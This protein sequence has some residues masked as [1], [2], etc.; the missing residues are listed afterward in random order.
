M[1]LQI[2][3]I[4]FSPKRF[5]KSHLISTSYNMNFSDTAMYLYDKKLGPETPG[6][7]PGQWG[8]QLV[9]VC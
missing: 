6:A 7:T 1:V 4:F 5:A 3:P 8:G 2:N 9:P